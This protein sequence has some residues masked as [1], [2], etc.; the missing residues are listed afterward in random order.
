[1]NVHDVVHRRYPWYI[2]NEFHNE[3]FRIPNVNPGK[4]GETSW[5]GVW[6]VWGAMFL[7]NFVKNVAPKLCRIILL[8]VGLVT[9]RFH[10]GKARKPIMF[11]VFG[12]L[13]VSMTP[14]TNITLETQNISKYLQM[15]QE[16]PKSFLKHNV[17]RNTSIGNR[18]FWKHGRGGGTDNPK[19]PSNKNWAAWMWV[20]DLSKT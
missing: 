1:M 19:V 17:F 15:T 16:H 11:M 6:V 20:Q 18:T 2:M 4:S 8:H 7:V 5:F 13:D 3:A 10:F 14:K 9:F 12:F